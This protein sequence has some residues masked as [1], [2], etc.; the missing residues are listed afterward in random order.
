[1]T[2]T[3]YWGGATAANQLEGAYNVDGRG[4]VLTD[5]TTGGTNKSPRMITYIDK[6]GNPGA[7]NK[8]EGHLPEG[9]RY[10][11]CDG[12]FYPNHEG[13]DFYHRYKEDIALFAEMGFKMF[14]MSI[15][16]AR[17]YPTGLEEK[18]NQ[19]GLD[20][21]H[22]VFR[23]LRKYGIEPMVSIWHFDTPLYIEEHYGNWQNRDVIDLYEKFA[24][25]CF[26]EFK[27]EVRYWITI[28][29]I[30][31]TAMFPTIKP[32]CTQKE[33]QDMY[34]QLHNQFVASARAVRIAHQ[35]DPENT[36]GNMI[37][38][39]VCYPETCHPKDVLYARHYMEQCIYYSSDV[40]VR[41]EYPVFAQR[42][43]DQYGIKLDITEQDLIDLKEGTI[44]MYTFSYYQ[45]Q[46]VSDHDE[47]TENKANKRVSNPFLG[48]N[49][50][51]QEIDP[52]GLR[53]FLELVNDRYHIPLFVVENGLGELDVLEE[54]NVVHDDYRIAYLRDHIR[55]IKN[56]LKNNVDVRGYLSWGP[57]DLVSAS[58]GEMRKRYG[59]IYV[60]R[61]DD[62]SGSMNRYRKDSFYWYKKVIASDGED[63]D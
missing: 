19:K 46:V 44:D 11:V 7:Y 39:L 1:M 15:S 12:Y 8:Y 25:T 61:N 36:V 63:L 33:A 32:D 31:L 37:A 42:I 40:Q 57:I 55:E 59:Y 4:M 34:Q 47:R 13:I 23:E 43:W 21:Y 26:E 49:S 53:Y 9:A 48:R 58:S 16:W 41:G 30:N 5:V 38:A 52:L 20:F 54:G 62:G 45:T 17:I 27:G 60:D 6:D 3:F 2:K 18:P 56:A 22:R 50:W 28:N 14:R 24:R 51:N 10:A 29:E 35:V